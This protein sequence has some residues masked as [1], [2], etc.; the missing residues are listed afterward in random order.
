MLW[1]PITVLICLIAGII[2]LYEDARGAKYRMEFDAYHRNAASLA[3]VAED[4]VMEN[5]LDY[6]LGY[7]LDEWKQLVQEF[8]GGNPEW[9]DYVDYS[10]GKLKAK[11]ATMARSGKLPSQCISY[12]V[13]LMLADD[14]RLKPGPHQIRPERGT[15]MNEDFMLKTAHVLSLRTGLNVNVYVWTTMKGER[16]TIHMQ[17]LEF[18]RTYGYGK[19]HYFTRFQFIAEKG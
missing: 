16:R 9:A 19:T 18:Q 13:S 1:I 15:Q 14:T 12:G 10:S 11:I 2:S 17:L 7:H 6:T 5:E 8:M 3:S 4:R